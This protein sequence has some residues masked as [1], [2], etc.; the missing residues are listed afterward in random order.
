[1]TPAPTAL[2]AARGIFLRGSWSSRCL[3]CV[4]N[5]RYRCRP[6]VKRLG[7][8]NKQPLNPQLFFLLSHSLSLSLNVVEVLNSVGR[9][10]ELHCLSSSGKETASPSPWPTTTAPSAATL[11]AFPPRVL[12]FRDWE[13]HCLTHPKLSSRGLP[14]VLPDLAVRYVVCEDSLF[15]VGRINSARWN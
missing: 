9:S 12:P 15:L 13:H 11:L 5:S 10:K 3:R 2:P 6:K 4:D 7:H 8:D 14:P 1:M